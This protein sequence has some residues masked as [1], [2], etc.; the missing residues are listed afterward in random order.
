M[1]S[2]GP[3]YKRIV[4][5][6]GS[7]VIAKNDGS[8][9]EWRVSQLVQDISV[10]F[11]WGIEVILVTSGAVAAGR[12]EVSVSRKTNL[13]SARQ[14]W[15]AIGQVKLMSKYQYF[16]S[17]FGI[18]AGQVL[19][20]KESFR[21]RTHYLNMK[22]CISAMFER[23]V[24]PVVNEND[25]VSVN[26]LMF[27]DNDELSGLISSMMDCT[28]LIILSNVDGLYDGKPGSEG[29]KLIRVV[30][31]DTEN[32]SSFI[33]SSGSGYG[34]GGMATKY[35]VVRKLSGEGIDV[36]IAN[37]TRDSVLIDI[38]RCKDIPCTLFRSGTM[39]E[40]SIRKW[41]SH[42]ETFARGAVIVNKGAREAI[43][44]GKAASLLMVGITAVEGYFRKGDI[45][46][47]LDEN[48]K[49]IGLGK[50]QYDSAKAQQSVGQKMKKP[51]IHCD[52]L[53]INGK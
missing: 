24:L 43:L 10:L 47:I 46:S 6:V 50:T 51:F 23:G 40:K 18:P 4:I 36:Y 45:V 20:T 30:E 1:K 5:K 31:P 22:S 29:S 44:A 37:G 41:I 17:K 3:K 33:S 32:L 35:S 34:R 21:D 49:S 7:N 11:K 19:A 13:V 53:V 14:V 8:I 48:R 42:S 9:N 12:S 26:E 52:Y 38:I 39:K 16:F 2:I 15:S 27:T 28:T 25:T